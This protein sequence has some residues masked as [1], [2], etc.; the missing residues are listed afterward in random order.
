MKDVLPPHGL[1][2]DHTSPLACNCRRAAAE[3][4]PW[5]PALRCAT[6]GMT[7]MQGYFVYILASQRNGT[8][9]TGVTNDLVRRISEHKQDL[10]PGFTAR[11]G[12]KTLV[13]WEAHDDIEQ[14]IL[15]EK[16]IKRWRRAWK[17]TLIETANPGWRDLYPELF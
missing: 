7:G 4:P 13:W 5:V 8:L 11:Y 6:A 12:V 1:E 14:A 2:L 3:A 17:L 10:A 16:R 15:R 9:Y